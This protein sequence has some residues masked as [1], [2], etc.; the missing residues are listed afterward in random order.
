MTSVKMGEPYY[1]VD[2]K[3]VPVKNEHGKF[4]INTKHPVT[5]QFSFGQNNNFNFDKE[6]IP[7]NLYR[8]ETPEF[9]HQIVK[10]TSLT[11]MNSLS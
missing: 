9:E 4:V 1:L 7:N 3:V 11:K 10:R 2:N 8:Q 5:K 6:N